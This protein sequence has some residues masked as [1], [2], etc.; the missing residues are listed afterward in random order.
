MRSLE[1]IHGVTILR[2]G[3]TFFELVQPKDLTNLYHVYLA[4][5]DYKA[6][7]LWAS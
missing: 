1:A 6:L 2:V 5:M 4:S 3:T 7:S